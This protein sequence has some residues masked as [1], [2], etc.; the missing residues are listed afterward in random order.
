MSVSR[1]AEHGRRAR[2]WAG[3][4]LVLATF[5]L[6]L[7]TWAGWWR[8]LEV[9]GGS[10]QPTISN[11]SLVVTT[12]RDVDQIG[13]GDVISFVG[14]DGK[15]VTHRVMAVDAETGEVTTR[16]DAN[17]VDDATPYAG[18]RVDLVRVAV[19]GLGVALRAIAMLT[20]NLWFIAGVVIAVMVLLPWRGRRRGRHVLD[21]AE[22][23]IGEVSDLQLVDPAADFEPAFGPEA[24]GARRVEIGVSRRLAVGS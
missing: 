15:R 6:G 3:G 24:T 2:A 1:V 18:H 16:G 9:Q 21:S 20:T 8:T 4:L 7:G 11:G 12:P 19:P 10:M 13:D 5:V 14:A 22:V 23:E 17:A